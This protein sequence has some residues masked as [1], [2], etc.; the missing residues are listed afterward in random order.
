VTEPAPRLQPG[1][2]RRR[3]RLAQAIRVRSVP[4]VRG[5][6]RASTY[7]HLARSLHLG[8]A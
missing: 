2:G 6:F 8:A 1:P 3:S 7:P 5:G 4:V